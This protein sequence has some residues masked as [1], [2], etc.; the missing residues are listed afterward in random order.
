[1]RS[2]KKNFKGDIE[3]DGTSLKPILGN[4]S[5]LGGLANEILSK[6]IH[7]QNL[8]YNGSFEYWYSGTSDVTPDAWADRGAD[9]VYA[10]SADSIYGSYSLSITPVTGS[11]TTLLTY[12]GINNYTNFGG[13]TLTLS[14]WVKTSG[15]NVELRLLDNSGE[16]S[17]SHTGGGD[18]EQLTVTRTITAS[19]TYIRCAIY[20]PTGDQ[21]DT[22]LV[23]GMMLVEGSAPFTFSPHPE[24]HLYKQSIIGINCWDVI[25]NTANTNYRGQINW[26]LGA[27]YA[28]PININQYLV[29]PIHIPTDINGK[30]II[31]DECV[32]YYNTQANDDYIDSIIIHQ[33]NGD[34][35]Y[36]N[37]VVHSADLGNGSSGDESHNIIDTQVELEDKPTYLYLK[38]AGTDTNT[39]VRFYSGIIKYHVKVHE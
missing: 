11:S 10:R 22:V 2:G 9:F 23:D 32:I 15:S 33:L 14:A 26:V 16:A 4:T 34:G 39:D 12:Q 19:P 3:G 17:A 35:S 21:G 31:I 28:Y 38:I 24:D 1:M 7:P 25:N 13:K 27:T 37:T 5:A 20:Q 18:W 36:T 8:L 29:F 6:D 30:T